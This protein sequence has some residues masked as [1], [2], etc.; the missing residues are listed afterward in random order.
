MAGRTR[1][2]SAWRPISTRYPSTACAWQGVTCTD[3]EVTVLNLNEAR[4]AGTIPASLGK[5]TTLTDLYLASN[6]FQGPV[7]SE[8]ARLPSLRVVD[9]SFNQLNES[10]PLFTSSGMQIIMLGHN[11]FTG[12]LSP[13]TGEG[14]NVLE[15]F[16]IKYNLL[17]GTI[18]FLTGSF[19]SLIELD[20]S[21]NRFLGKPL[22]V[23]LIYI[24]HAPQMLSHTNHSKELSLNSLVNSRPYSDCT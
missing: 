17:T 16:N 22:I 13:R 5:V 4:L 21:N 9:L 19:P 3:G 7:P 1:T 23:M 18:P 12:E 14:M 15:I 10:L 2:T 11:Q 20:L 6:S 8:V 24:S